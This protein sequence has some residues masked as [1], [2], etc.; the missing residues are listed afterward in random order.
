MNKEGACNTVIKNMIHQNRTKQLSDGKDIF[1]STTID[2][3]DTTNKS[4]YIEFKYPSFL[5]LNF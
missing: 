4:K 5:N 2:F 1:N 3:I